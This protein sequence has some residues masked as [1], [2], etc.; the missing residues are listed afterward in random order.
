MENRSS[1]IRQLLLPPSCKWPSKPQ[2]YFAR[3]EEG[4]HAGVAAAAVSIGA[5]RMLPD[6]AGTAHEAAL[7]WSH[8]EVE[9]APNSASGNHRCCLLAIMNRSFTPAWWI[10][11]MGRHQAMRV[12]LQKLPTLPQSLSAPGTLA[13]ASTPHV[14]STPAVTFFLPPARRQRVQLRRHRLHFVSPRSTDGGACA[15]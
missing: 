13:P 10:C 9:G 14:P 8:A 15:S 3:V 4:K 7:R 5:A 1:T 11:A 12:V 6:A 2:T